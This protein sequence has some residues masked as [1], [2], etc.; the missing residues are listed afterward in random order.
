MKGDPAGKYPDDSYRERSC[1]RH[2]PKYQ[3]ENH[4]VVLDENK[5]GE[6]PEKGVQIEE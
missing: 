4:N 3:G 6:N 2:R 5:M 1:G